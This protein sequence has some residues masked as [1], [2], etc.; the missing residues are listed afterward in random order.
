[1][2]QAKGGQANWTAPV[3]ASWPA[4][5]EGN[6]KLENSDGE[7]ADQEITSFVVVPVASSRSSSGIEGEIGV[8]DS[9]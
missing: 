6:S 4:L 8:R 3:G 2:T 1:M 5:Y 7:S 9:L